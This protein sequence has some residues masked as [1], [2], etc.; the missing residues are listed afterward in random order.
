MVDEETTER[1][2]QLASETVIKISNMVKSGP[3]DKSKAAQ[4]E[5]MKL[6]LAQSVKMS[7][8]FLQV[9]ESFQNFANG[10]QKEA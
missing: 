4:R 6:T 10:Q 3:K 7:R 9:Y 5:L 8:Y 2:E 1:I